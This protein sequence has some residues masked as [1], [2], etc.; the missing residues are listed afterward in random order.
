MAASFVFFI[1]F[2]FSFLDIFSLLS[3]MYT[4]IDGL[5]SFTSV[6]FCS[7][8]GMP[9][10]MRRA[11]L[12]KEK[13]KRITRESPKKKFFFSL[14]SPVKFAL[15][16]APLSIRC[17][18]DEKVGLTVNHC[19]NGQGKNHLVITHIRCQTVIDCRYETTKTEE[20]YEIPHSQGPF[21]IFVVVRC[22]RETSATC[23]N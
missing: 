9:I 21:S 20:K 14:A 7:V 5:H 1:F 23:S 19:E 4:N 10:K 22:R 11:T 2:F 8:Y 18:L 15:S 12:K 6:W 17:R 13:K 16:R 3:R